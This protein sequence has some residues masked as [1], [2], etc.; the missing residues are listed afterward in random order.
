[1]KTFLGIGA[2]HFNDIYEFVYR[3]L[4]QFNP[5]A[6]TLEKR[7]NLSYGLDDTSKTRL[8]ILL[9]GT[10]KVRYEK[11]MG[12]AVKNASGGIKI[13]L[14]KIKQVRLCVDDFCILDGSDLEFNP[15]L[16][17]ALE[18]NV[19]FYLIDAPIRKKKAIVKFHGEK[20]NVID[21]EYQVELT[22]DFTLD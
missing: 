5:E 7:I 14:N 15:A 4:E 13:T 3:N 6:I 12:G 16:E 11:V 9:D 19:P 20:Y 1:M 18:R 22:K 17:Y 8:N 2:S 10:G 21:L